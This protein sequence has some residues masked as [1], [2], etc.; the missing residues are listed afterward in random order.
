[1]SCAINSGFRARPLAFKFLAG[2][3]PYTAA[4]NLQ[5]ALVA[6]R[7]RQLY[8]SDTRADV[9]EKHSNSEKSPRE[10][11][12][13]SKSLRNSEPIKL[14]DKNR[15]SLQNSGNTPEV[16]DLQCAMD[17]LMQAGD[18]SMADIVLMLQHPPTYTAGRRLRGT[19]SG[20]EAKRLHQLGADYFEVHVGYRTRYRFY[21]FLS[22]IL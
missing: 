12:A 9:N 17:A 3:T 19:A 18:A 1:M 6:C 8:P 4:L 14:T 16:L 13:N 2:Y 20:E 5:N 10:T 21:L 22:I 15:K 7:I 11:T